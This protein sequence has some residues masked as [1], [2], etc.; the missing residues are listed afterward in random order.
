M[1]TERTE[2]PSNT[3]RNNAETLLTTREAAERLGMHERTVR[4]AIAR[5]CGMYCS[6]SAAAAVAQAGAP[7][8]G[9]A[10]RGEACA[11][12]AVLSPVLAT[13]LSSLAALAL[14]ACRVAM[15]QMRRGAV[16]FD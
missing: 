3:P 8:T 1:G 10:R 12:S 6:G 14:A 2:R 13:A 15:A 5:C 7:R 9:L 4:R 11:L 16:R